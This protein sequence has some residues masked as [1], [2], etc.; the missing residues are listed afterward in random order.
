MCFQEKLLKL[1]EL[2]S[3]VCLLLHHIQQSYKK[4]AFHIRLSALKQGSAPIHSHSKTWMPRKG[5]HQLKLYLA[6]RTGMSQSK[7]VT[8][9]SS[10]YLGEL[11]A[12]VAF[13]QME[14]VFKSNASASDMT[15]IEAADALDSCK[16]KYHRMLTNG[17]ELKLEHDDRTLSDL[18]VRDESQIATVLTFLQCEDVNSDSSSK[19][20]LGDV[21]LKFPG[22]LYVE[23]PLEN[24]PQVILLQEAHFNQLFHLLRCLS[25]LKSVANKVSERNSHSFYNIQMLYELPIFQNI[26][27]DFLMEFESCKT[28]SINFSLKMMI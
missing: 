21:F 12:E 16:L 22:C 23:P 9:Q 6:R 3:I 28:R 10:D 11:R 13:H 14:E 15:A 19:F 20:Q 8:M 4:Y 2:Q 27:Y 17:L 1:R 24:Y 26:V 18:C 5:A 25:N 7:V